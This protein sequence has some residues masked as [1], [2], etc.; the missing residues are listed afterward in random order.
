MPTPATQTARSNAPA[1][2]TVDLRVDYGAVVAV[3]ELSLT[4]G[5]GEVFGLIGPNGAGKTSTIRVLA[6]LLEPTYG[7]VSIGGFDVSTH[8]ADARR[9]LGYM[10]DLPPVYDELTV[11]E[12]LDVF[13][14][15]YELPIER[16]RRRVNE[17]IELVNLGQKRDERAGGLSRGMK[18][19]LVLAKTLLHDPS[20]LLLDEPA[21]GL[22]PMARIELRELLKQLGAEGKTV[23]VSSHI[24]TEL[25]DFC[26]SIGIM[27]KGAMV[28]SGSIE[29]IA[30]RMSPH[31]TLAVRAVS[32]VA[33][34]RAVLLSLPKVVQVDDADGELLVRFDSNAAEEVAELLASLV[35]AGVR[36]QSFYERKLDVEDIFLEVG[37]SEVS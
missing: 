11:W 7:D 25:S 35:R 27:Q 22:D 5:Q 14:G 2:E 18:Q 6:T 13:A 20:V 4:I 12:F 33:D 10:P 17:C 1:I 36:V 28:V 26:T 9:V 32:P 21:S 3:R 29:D 30:R 19:R 24:L 8:A 23:L 34:A 15:T 16:R 31:K 37:A